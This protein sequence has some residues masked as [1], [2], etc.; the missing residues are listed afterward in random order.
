MRK[1]NIFLIVLILFLAVA[2]YLF[3]LGEQTARRGA[4]LKLEGGET[5]DYS[6]D[7]GN[8][9]D[10]NN[11]V[12]ED[13]APEKN[14][15]ENSREGLKDNKEEVSA[16]SE[17][18]ADKESPS[19]SPDAALKISFD[20]PFTPQ[21]PNGEWD[22]SYFQNG[23][24]EAAALMAVYWARGERENI[25]PAKA[26]S[27]IIAA[28][29]YEIE[30]MGEFMD[31]SMED[32][33]N[34]IIKGYFKY[35]NAELKK[36]ISLDDIIAEL[37]KGNLVIAHTNGQLLGNP[38]YT[39]PGPDRHSLVITGYEKEANEFIVNDPG[40]KRGEKFRY[41]KNILYSAIRDYPT[42]HHEPIEKIEKNIIVVKK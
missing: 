30:K 31:A 2:G 12:K 32:T 34:I 42:G 39:P 35:E 15:E 8:N 18:T 29:E 17:K 6:D 24:E 38:Y 14:I 37:K 19:E 41:N 5:V 40:T 25:A 22:N 4:N 13:P 11:G 27:E 7:A 1:N 21:A 16:P 20:V 3:Y 23:C 9:N 10:F 28:S 36:N 26:M 33:L